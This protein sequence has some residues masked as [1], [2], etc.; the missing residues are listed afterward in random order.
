MPAPG[1]RFAQTVK[2]ACRG[3]PEGHAIRLSPAGAPIVSKFPAVDSEDNH[4][5]AAN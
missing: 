1:L 5:F 3:G 4:R 2:A